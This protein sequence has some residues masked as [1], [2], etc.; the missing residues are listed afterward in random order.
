MLCHFS[1]LTSWNI[2]H[3]FSFMFELETHFVFLSQT[4]LKNLTTK[5][6]KSDPK[7]IATQNINHLY[8]NK[9]G[10]LVCVKQAN[11]RHIGRE[12]TEHR[13]LGEVCG[14]QWNF[15][16]IISNTRCSIP[17]PTQ[18]YPL[19]SNPL[20]APRC[21]VHLPMPAGHIQRVYTFGFK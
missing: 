7:K 10:Q 17:H 16:Q 4:N 9:L 8:V 6:R 5:T 19:W 2:G 13:T 11:S 3:D 12:R 20:I 15:F 1:A 18:I 21:Y 14:V